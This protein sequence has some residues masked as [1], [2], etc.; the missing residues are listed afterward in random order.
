MTRKRRGSHKRDSGKSL[1]QVIAEIERE[2]REKREP[3]R[4]QT[5]TVN[6]DKL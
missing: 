3:R 2:K 6:R 5:V 4:V 1:Q